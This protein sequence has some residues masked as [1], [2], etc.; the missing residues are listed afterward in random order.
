MGVYFL[1]YDPYHVKKVSIRHRAEQRQ[2]T[3][4]HQ[5]FYAVFNFYKVPESRKRGV[6][7][8][9]MTGIFCFEIFCKNKGKN[10]LRGNPNCG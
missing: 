8:C 4:T 1:I 2:N 3:Q 10:Q 6:F 5:R 7:M 9:R